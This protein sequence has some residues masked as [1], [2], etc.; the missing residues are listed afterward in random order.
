MSLYNH[1]LKFVPCMF[2]ITQ[3]CAFMY[4]SWRALC[5][6]FLFPS[7]NA[8]VSLVTIFCWEAFMGAFI[9]EHIPLLPVLSH[10]NF[11][12][13]KQQLQQ[14]GLLA[15]ANTQPHRHHLSHY[16]APTACYSLSFQA[17]W[18]FLKCSFVMKKVK[19]A[20][21]LVV[22]HNQGTCTPDVSLHLQRDCG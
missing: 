8:K 21:L 13:S 12:P 19:N 6:Q 22:L 7:V 18:Q 9:N 1:V 5:L 11:G 20:C 16:H 10:S 3:E 14:L 2:F 15:K 17:A 4:R